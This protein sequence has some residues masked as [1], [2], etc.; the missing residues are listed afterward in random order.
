MKFWVLVPSLA[1]DRSFLALGF[2]HL[3]EEVRL[4]VFKCSVGPGSASYCSYHQNDAGYLGS[5]EIKVETKPTYA[6]S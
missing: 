3:S 4:Q 1:V 6:W 2:P 5:C